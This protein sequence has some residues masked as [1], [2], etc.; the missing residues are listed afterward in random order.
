MIR[1]N[2]LRL[3]FIMFASL[4]LVSVVSAFAANNVVPATHLTEQSRAITASELAPSECNSIRSTLTAIR[5]CVGGSCNGSNA[6]EL[7]LGTAG[8]DEIDGKNGNDCIIGGDG[9]DN[10]NG[11]NDDDVIL[12]AGGNDT[13]DGGPKKDTDICYGGPGTNTFIECDQTP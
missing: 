12:G 10:L 2:I 13:L 3:A 5:V 8:Y 6:N 9:D 1:K 7:I 11:G 4:I